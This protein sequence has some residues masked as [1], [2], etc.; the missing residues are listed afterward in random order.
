MNM[1]LEEPIRTIVVIAIN[2]VLFYI[3]SAILCGI[4][5]RRDSKRWTWLNI[6]MAALISVAWVFGWGYLAGL[7]SATVITF[8]LIIFFL[9]WIVWV[10]I[11]GVGDKSA[12]YATLGTLILW[13]L[14]CW[15]FMVIMNLTNVT[16]FNVTDFPTLLDWLP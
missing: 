13:F 3:A 4:M 11:G 6:I 8:G 1:A 14:L 16:E 2:F 10:T 9:C 5:F 12:V 15:V 7:G